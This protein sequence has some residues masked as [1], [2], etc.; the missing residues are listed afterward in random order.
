MSKQLNNG[1]NTYVQGIEDGL[2]NVI[3]EF[4]KF[5]GGNIPDKNRDEVVRAAVLC[6]LSEQLTMAVQ[7]KADNYLDAEA[8]VQA[9]N[10]TR[11][12]YGGLIHNLGDNH[13]INISS[14]F[15]RYDT[16]E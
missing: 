7:C 6:W 10:C 2:Q 9:N 11:F 14:I 3:H 4:G 15:R 8:T 13:H 1:E 16:V 12:G 5:F